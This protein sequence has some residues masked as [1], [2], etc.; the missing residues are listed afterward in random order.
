MLR[1]MNRTPA[2]L[3]VLLTLSLVACSASEPRGGGRTERV[4]DEDGWSTSEDETTEPATE[5]AAPG[6]SAP[7]E[8]SDGDASPAAPGPFEAPKP[9][10]MNSEADASGDPDTDVIQFEIEAFELAWQEEYTSK[11][12]ALSKKSALNGL[13]AVG[14]MRKLKGAS[15]RLDKLRLLW[16]LRLAQSEL[17]VERELMSIINAS[18][19][20]TWLARLEGKAREARSAAGECGSEATLKRGFEQVAALY[21]RT[22]KDWQ[23]QNP[24]H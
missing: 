10:D 1:S 2:G 18:N 6:V 3:A 22:I 11:D 5:S 24:G 14:K 13:T 9:V 8:T 21:S 17:M 20:K 4:K 12:Y 19:G 7:A 15:T 16:R 23:Q